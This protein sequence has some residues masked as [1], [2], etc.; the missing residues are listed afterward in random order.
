MVTTLLEGSNSAQGTHVI[1]LYKPLLCS[2]ALEIF[3]LSIHF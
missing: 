1:L 2:V 3:Y